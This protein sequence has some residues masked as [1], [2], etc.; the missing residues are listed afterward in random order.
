MALH[1]TGDPTSGGRPAESR[2]VL[3]TGMMLDQHLAVET[4]RAGHVRGGN[5]ARKP[6]AKAT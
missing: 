4:P 2:F 5:E 1:I 6:A 3:L